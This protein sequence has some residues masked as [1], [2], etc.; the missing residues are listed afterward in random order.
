MSTL[1]KQVQGA[2]VYYDSVYTHRW[3]DAFG[4]NVLKY[5]QEFVALP[6]DDGT[7]DP[8]E[9]EVTVVEL[10]AGTSTAVVTDVAGGAL[11]ITTAGDEDDGWSMQLGAVAGENVYFNGDYDTYFGAKFQVSDATDS[12]ILVG[13]TV[14]DTAVLGGVTDGMYFRSV[15]GSTDLCFYTEKDSVEGNTTVAT[16]ANAT[17]VT[18]EFLFNGVDV[19]PYANGVPFAA[20]AM[21]AAT[22]PDDEVLR[23]TVE[24]LNGAAGAETCT[25]KWLKLIHLRG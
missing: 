13:L 6:A 17:D 12:D 9:W 1:T 8:T 16:L 2:L 5:L 20:T 23:L 19:T 15:D 24:F 14:T 10:G 4:P 11:L 18:V 21:S 25:M 22:W 3:Y 7:G